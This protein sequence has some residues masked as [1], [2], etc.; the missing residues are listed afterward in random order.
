MKQN[1]FNPSVE[2]SSG[3]VVVGGWE[4]MDV[5]GSA[6]FAV[7]I[8]GRPIAAAASLL[9]T[10]TSAVVKGRTLLAAIAAKFPETAQC[11]TQVS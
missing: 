1:T 6:G 7:E 3:W 2:A 10:V 9:Y 11:Y 8:T 4:W 5:L